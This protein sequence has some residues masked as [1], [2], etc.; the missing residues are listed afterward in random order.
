ST[1]SSTSSSSATWRCRKPPGTTRS[2]ARRA[3]RGP[4]RRVECGRGAWR[5]G[6]RQRDRGRFVLPPAMELADARRRQCRRLGD[7][8]RAA[9]ARDGPADRG[10]RRGHPSRPPARQL[11]PAAAAAPVRAGGARPR[12]AARR[13]GRGHRGGGGRGGARAGQRSRRRGGRGDGRVTGSLV[14]AAYGAGM[15]VAAMLAAIGAHLPGAKRRWPTLAGRLGKLPAPERA[16]AQGGDAIWLH[17]ASVGELVAV[18]PLLARLRERFPGRVFV[19][20]TLTGTGLAL[21]RELSEAHLACLFPLDAPATV[22]RRLESFRLEAFL[23]TETEI[24][25]SFLAALA[26]RGVPA[27]LVS[28]RV[29]ARTAGRAWGLRPLYRRG[30][31]PV[32]CCMQTE[33]DA[34]RI[35]AAGRV[36]LPPGPAVLLLDVVGPLAHCYAL[37]WVAFV[38]GSLVPAGGHNVLEP[39]RAARPILVGPHTEHSAALVARLAAAG[40]LVRVES[41]AALTAA[42]GALLGDVERTTA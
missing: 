27:I 18:R 20:S 33:A 24:W 31:T 13:A 25:P 5:G 26:G 37:G 17:A 15:T 41:P 3:G 1:G 7:R 6:A 28:G 22:R 35:V 38:G 39:A 4:A 29:S 34:R 36:V 16:A 32:T 40:G 14:R 19:V 42:L 8:G 9:R 11:G 10:D 30:L 23:F 21:A 2:S 12:R